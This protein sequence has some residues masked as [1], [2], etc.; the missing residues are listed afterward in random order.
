V[1]ISTFFSYESVFAAFMYLQFGFVIFWRNEIF[2]KAAR[3]ILVKLN[4]VVVQ[5]RRD[6]LT[7][8]K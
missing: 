4:T 3:K 6:L 1:S 8:K 7:H 2:K 5:H